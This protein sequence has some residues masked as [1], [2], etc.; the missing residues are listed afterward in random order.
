[1]KL[2]SHGHECASSVQ[3]SSYRR[4]FLSIHYSLLSELAV[5]KHGVLSVL[6]HQRIVIADFLDVAVFH[7]KDHSGIADYANA[8]NSLEEKLVDLVD[9]I[10]ELCRIAACA[11]EQRN[12][13]DDQDRNGDRHY[14]S[15]VA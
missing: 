13:N 12:H 11:D 15:Y 5:V 9:H 3:Q 8:L 4:L 1:M 14:D 10:S 6:L 2:L 7:I